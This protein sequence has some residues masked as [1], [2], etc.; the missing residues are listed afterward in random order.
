[1][2]LPLKQAGLKTSSS[3]EGNHNVLPYAFT[4][5][6][7]FLP[8]CLLPFFLS[9]LLSFCPPPFLPFYPPAFLPFCPLAFLPFCPPW[10]YQKNPKVS[11]NSPFPHLPKRQRTLQSTRENKERSDLFGAQRQLGAPATSSERSDN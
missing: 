3:E 8:S 11:F 4:L 1:M 10:F 9:A 7:T 5:P 6:P 2:R